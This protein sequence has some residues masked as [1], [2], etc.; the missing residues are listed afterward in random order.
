M[1]TRG[2]SQA[3]VDALRAAAYR[4]PT[5]APEADS[6]FAWDATT[7]VTVEVDAAGETGIGYTYSDASIVALIQHTLAA[8]VLKHDVWDVRAHWQ[9]MQRQVRNLGRAGL[10]ATAISAID[11]ALWDVK[12]KLVASGLK[13]QPRLL[14]ALHDKHAPGNLAH[15][16]AA[17]SFNQS[18]ALLALSVLTDSAMEHYRGSFNNP[19]M[20]APLVVASL[21]LGAGLHG[22]KAPPIRAVTCACITTAAIHGKRSKHAPAKKTKQHGRIAVFDDAQHHLRGTGGRAPDVFVRGGWVPMREYPNREEVD[23]AMVGTGAG[24]GALA[25]RLAEH[26][27]KV[28]AFD[29]GAWWRPLD[30]FASDET[31]QEKLFWTDDRICDGENPL[32][33]GNNNS[34]K[35]VGGSTVH[36][37]MVSLRFR[38]EW[39]K[40]R[41]L[42]GYGADWPLDWREMWRYYAQVEDALKIAGPV[43]YPWGPRRP[44]YPY[45]AHELNAA[46]LVLGR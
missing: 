24:G 23:F 46:A 27:L 7:L 33:R 10:A 22:G 9:R 16:Q 37:A 25:C 41:S 43:D 1:A 29:A 44:R 11:C 17:R 39:F 31:H 20:W 42:L 30:K 4:I 34:G 19:A 2:A 12:A 26:G 38:P 40:S 32:K 13:P 14:D 28:V 45:R 21:S 5:D 35:S 36:F 15:I 8:Y 3:P 18:S 6:T